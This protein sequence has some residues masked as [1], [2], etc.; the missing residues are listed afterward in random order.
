MNRRGNGGRSH[1]AEEATDATKRRWT[2]IWH[3]R[4][5]KSRLELDGKSDLE[6]QIWKA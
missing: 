3:A 5:G 2:W 1:Q 4:N 6:N